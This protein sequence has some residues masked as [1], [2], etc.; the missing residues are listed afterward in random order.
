MF[1]HNN[2]FICPLQT[3]AVYGY[4]DKTLM[5]SSTLYIYL[6]YF[7]NNKTLYINKSI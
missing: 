5:R 2:M 7:I 3:H 1:G 4:H 6:D